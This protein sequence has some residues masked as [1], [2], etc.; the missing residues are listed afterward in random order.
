MRVA[1]QRLVL[2]VAVALTLDACAVLDPDEGARR[3]IASDFVISFSPV[4]SAFEEDHDYQVPL[5]AEPGVEVDRWE[6]VDAEGYLQDDVADISRWAEINGVVLRPRRAGD[7]V[8]LA[9]AGERTGCTEL[10]VTQGTPELWSLGEQRYHNL[11]RLSSQPEAIQLPEDVS[12]AS[13]HGTGASFLAIEYTPLQTAGLSDQQLTAAIT[14]GIRP[15]RSQASG[16]TRCRPYISNT[17]SSGVPAAIY[18]YF[19][20]WQA[21]ADEGAALVQYLRSLAPIPEAQVVSGPAEE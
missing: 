11:L 15:D 16:P 2:L 4:Y 3:D 12:C 8:V 5:F 20:T 7:Y 14:M 13:C 6:V 10:H 18:R 1:I 17:P 9:H 19:H 21:T